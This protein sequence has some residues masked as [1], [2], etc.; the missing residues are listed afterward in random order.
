M[1]HQVS[2]QAIHRASRAARV[3]PVALALAGVWVALSL[4]GCSTYDLDTGLS[5]ANRQTQDFTEQAVQLRQSPQARAQAERLSGQLLDAPL[6]QKEAVQLM[7]ANS[8]SFQALLA[9]H[10]ADAAWAAQSG[11]IANPVFAF[12]QVLTG[13][14]AEL[15]RFLSVGL[16]EVM[17]L[18]WRARL[19]ERRLAQLQAR[20]GGEI[21]DQV[22]Q[23]RQ[24]W[25][26]AVA[27]RELAQF[28]QQVYRN[29][30]ASAELARRMQGVGNFNAL[31]RA[32]Y[33]AFYAE[34]AAQLALAQQAETARRE[35]LVRKL[36]LDEA[37]SR[38]LALPDQL[39]ALPAQP[40][41][42]EA[43]AHRA[44]QQRLDVR[45]A[46]AS[47][48]AAARA[49]GL[50]LVTSYTDIELSVR[51]GQVTDR[52]TGVTTGRQGYEIGVRLP[53]FD[54]GGLRRDAMTA[55]TL[56]AANRLEATVRDAASSLRESYAAYR[57]A[58]DVSRHY[59]DEV[60]PLRRQ[61]SEENLLRYNAM[62]MGVFEL[63][64]DARDQVGAVMAAIQAQQQYWL[65]DAALQ[66]TLVGRP[67]S[68]AMATPAAG[69]AAAPAAGGH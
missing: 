64:A 54:W 38:R 63:L 51:R 65:A 55:H 7:L 33:Q 69:A 52:D 56:V 41:A 19:S 31:T 24:A 57:T 60:L 32:R 11:R 39:P 8:P 12:E 6:G 30:E 34:A 45:Q 10:W 53:V 46:Q 5:E 1:S 27:A 25:V 59:R 35:E 40:L 67:L 4:A 43:A 13:S 29:A 21:V 49:Q 3:R 18:P 22:T 50:N 48:E 23:V 44:S 17:T 47:L 2:H 37:Q 61:I 20:L 26:R 16:L 36:G 15:D 42:P 14:E 68:V 58:Y 28:Q 9:Q 66:S 62:L